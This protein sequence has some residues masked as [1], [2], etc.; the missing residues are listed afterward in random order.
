M[1]FLNFIESTFVSS[2]KTPLPLC[3]CHSCYSFLQMLVLPLV[4]LAFLCSS[5]EQMLVHFNKFSLLSFP[6]TT[7]KGTAHL[8]CHKAFKINVLG[9]DF[10]SLLSPLNIYSHTSTKT[11]S[12]AW[13]LG[14]IWLL[15]EVS[16][17]PNQT[18]VFD[19][20]QCRVCCSDAGQLSSC[21]FRSHAHLSANFLPGLIWA[22]TSTHAVCK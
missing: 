3:I 22:W 1:V 17:H 8:E 6:V 10:A 15:K 9:L 11:K 18:R 21:S 19:S 16:R 12:L 2:T 14:N 5:E 20:Q 4:S 7:M 13:L